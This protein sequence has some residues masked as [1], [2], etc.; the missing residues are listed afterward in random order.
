MKTH[1][2]DRGNRKLYGEELATDPSFHTVC[3]PVVFQAAINT[4]EII[5]ETR[6]GPRGHGCVSVGRGAAERP[7]HV[8]CSPKK[9]Y[10]AL[11]TACLPRDS[12]WRDGFTARMQ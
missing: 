12:D 8:V 9:E 1:Y 2:D 10:L 6:D 7:I 4:M 5:R 11:I 3:K